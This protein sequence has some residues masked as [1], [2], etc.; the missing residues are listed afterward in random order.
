MT[1]MKKG[2]GQTKRPQ[3][4]GRRGCS[5]TCR[6][7][8]EV[9]RMLVQAEADRAAASAAYLTHI[10]WLREVVRALTESLAQMVKLGENMYA[11]YHE[12]D[13]TGYVHF[14]HVPQ[15]LA[16]IERHGCLG[17]ILSKVP[18]NPTR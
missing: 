13:H 7:L 6:K 18:G 4:R 5:A 3:V 16:L 11:S 17:T 8:E 2:G 9:K 1:K 14:D 15:A 10:D 12:G